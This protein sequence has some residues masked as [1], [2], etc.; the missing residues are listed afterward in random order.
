[1]KSILISSILSLI[2]TGHN[3]VSY[4]YPGNI[5]TTPYGTCTQYYSLGNLSQEGISGM[6]NGIVFDSDFS[7][8]FIHYEFAGQATGQFDVPIYSAI[9]NNTGTTSKYKLF[10]SGGYLLSTPIIG[11]GNE[12][13]AMRFQVVDSRSMDILIIHP[14]WDQTA[15]SFPNL[16]NQNI[17]LTQTENA[18][19]NEILNYVSYDSGQIQNIHVDTTMIK[20]LLISMSGYTA[21]SNDNIATDIDSLISAINTA[22]SISTDINNAL[23]HTNIYDNLVYQLIENNP[24]YQ[25]STS[26]GYVHLYGEQYKYL[27]SNNTSNINYYNSFT[28]PAY[29]DMSFVLFVDRGLSN[30]YR[31][32]SNGCSI[33]RVI[34]EIVGGVYL[35]ELII[36]NPT[37][38]RVECSIE[39][40]EDLYLSP[41][42]LCRRDHMPQEIQNLL[43]IDIADKYTNRLEAIKRA[44]ENMSMNVNQLTVNATGITYNVNNTQVNN[45][46]TTYN[47]NINQVYNIENNFGTQLD[48]QLQ[49]YNPD[50]TSIISRLTASGNIMATVLNGING[51]ELFTIPISVMLVGIVLL[52]IVG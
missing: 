15:I 3:P 34:Y 1:M 44:I 8:T 26:T 33:S 19:I 31:L 42:L 9:L 2:I 38:A 5:I 49:N 28:V 35:Y 43:G 16:Y 25:S 47:T 6:L 7:M 45:S 22:N 24:R 29:T 27:S 17:T 39:F 40:T 48:T 46:V 32:Y 10:V 52:A 20:N 36:N 51:I 13:D 41:V 18:T 14:G 11:N 12:A 37:S 23:K 50:N 21:D 4:A 30:N